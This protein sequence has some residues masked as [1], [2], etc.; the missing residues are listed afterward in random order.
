MCNEDTGPV[1]PALIFRGVTE[2]AWVWHA[3][4]GHVNFDELEYMAKKDLVIGMP[5]IT[6]PK[7]MC[8]GCMVAKQ[9]RKP[10]PKEA[11]WRA[12]K[13][14]ELVHADL[15][16]PITPSTYGGN[17]YFLLIVDDFS[18]FMWVYLLK[19][20]DEAFTMFKKFKAEVEQNNPYQVKMLRTDR[21][22]E[23]NSLQFNDFCQKM[24]I[25]RQLTAPYTPH[26]NGVVERRNRTVVE[27]TRSL[28][29]TMSVPD[30]MWGEAV[31]HS[32]YLLNRVLTKSVKGATPYE[33]LKGEK[34]KLSHV[35]VFGCTAYVKDVSKKLTQL[36][37]RG[38]PMVHLGR[39]EEETKGYRLLNPKTLKVVVA[40]SGIVEFD[41]FRKWGWKV[42]QNNESIAPWW[43]NILSTEPEPTN[44]SNV[45]SSGAHPQSQNNAVNIN[46]LESPNLTSTQSVPASA[47]SHGSESQASATSIQ[48]SSTD[49]GDSTVPFDNSPIQGFRSLDGVYQETNPMT[50]N[51]VRE[52]YDK[53]DELFLIDGEPT[54]YDEAATEESWLN[55]MK[56]ELASIKRN[57]TWSLTNLPAGQ[58]AIGVRWVF[59]LKKNA[60]GK[61]IKHKARLV[62]KGYVQKKGIDFEDAFAPVAR[63]E[64]IRLLLAVTAKESWVVHHMDVKSAFLNGEL[65]EEV[66]VTQPTGFEIKGKEQIVYRLHRALYGKF[67]KSRSHDS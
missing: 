64:T 52:L 60:E 42:S 58:R 11:H 35:K 43:A 15:C 40:S 53:E 61:I 36:S 4:M 17:R 39:A 37:D 27:M 41:E 29:K 56:E 20:K 49:T 45:Q 13:P 47:S 31:R 67:I 25:R 32:V 18:C 55:A 7:Q 44:Q 2:E 14:L 22:G 3:R 28:L 6:H 66:Y 59:K 8:E 34:P 51:Q 16:G 38:T 54:S 1:T 10:V 24:K 65:V 33:V 19:T 57:N 63:I 46:S 30:Q 26:Q 9:M 21:G 12:S 5:C 62:A 23:F 50:P 48:S